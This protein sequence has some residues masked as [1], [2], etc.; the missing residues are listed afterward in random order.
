MAQSNHE[1][2]GRALELLNTGLKPFVEREM[3]A[4]Y[5]P[6]WQYEAVKA[7]REQH[8]TD[9]GLHLDAQGLLLILWDQWQQVFKNVLGHSERSLVSEL[10]ETR[11]KW[12][13]QTAFS[14]DDAYR[15]LDSV[16]RL[17]TAV[18]AASE[19]GEVERQKQELLRLRFEE[20]ARNET[21]KVSV[22]P[23]EGRPGLGLRPWREIVTPHPDVASGHYASA[24]FAADLA[25]VARGLGADEYRVPRDFFQRTYL[26]Y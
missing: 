16:Q 10:R 8:I 19:A 22:T 6:R 13:H 25:Q 5:G 7:L 21:R 14:T 17:L 12:A 9:D 15:A 24:E 1:R 26:T 2:V 20:Q 4:N 18:S 11:N 3:Q 23:V